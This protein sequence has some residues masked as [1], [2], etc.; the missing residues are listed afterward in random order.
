MI[1]RGLRPPTLVISDGGPGLIGAVELVWPASG[2]QRCLIHRCRNLLAKVLKHAQDQLKADFWTIWDIVTE[3]GD[4]AVA[5]ARWRVK[6]IGRLPAGRS[7]LSLVWAVL[8]RASRGWRGVEMTP[9]TVRHLQQ[10]RF[11][12]LGPPPRPATP[13]RAVD[14]RVTAAA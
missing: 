11:E 1:A 6:V 9:K 12:L 3:A 14:Q 13:D 10:L 4:D 7:C 8:D 2:R 5:E